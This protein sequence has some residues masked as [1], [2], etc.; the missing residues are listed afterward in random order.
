AGSGLDGGE[1]E[2]GL[3]QAL[4]RGVYC[5]GHSTTL[6]TSSGGDFPAVPEGRAGVFLSFLRTRI[7]SESATFPRQNPVILSDYVMTLSQRFQRP[8]RSLQFPLGARE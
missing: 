7:H 6:R 5:G 8:S 3:V 2:S 1:G 4:N